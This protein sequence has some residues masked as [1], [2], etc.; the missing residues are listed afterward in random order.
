MRVTDG[1]T[2]WYVYIL[3]CA[4]GTLYTGATTDVARRSAAHNAGRGAK[5]TKTRRPCTLVYVQA[6]GEHGAALSR[7]AAIKRMP[8]PEKLRLIEEWKHRDTTQ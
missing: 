4:D 5:Y 1:K 6:V 7:E 2:Q 3:R 8:R